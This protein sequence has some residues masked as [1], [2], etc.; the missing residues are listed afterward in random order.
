M[1]RLLQL[2]C[3]LFIAQWS[4]AQ[5]DSIPFFKG[6]LKANRD[7]AYLN[8][9]N[10]IVKKLSLPLVDSTEQDWI[11]AFYS[12]ELIRYKD[13]W[14]VSKIR[15][16]FDSISTRSIDFQVALLE[17][18][19]ANYPTQF[20]D[21]IYV[22]GNETMNAKVYAMV[23][24]YMVQSGDIRMAGIL[25]TSL[26]RIP[27]IE[28]SDSS[29]TS[30]A[31]L[32]A[33][34]CK[35]KDVTDKNFSKKVKEIFKKK[36]LL[37]NTIVYSI[38]RK[39]RN[40]P[41]I[42]IVKDKTGSYVKDEKGNIFSVPQLARSITNMPGYI[43]NGNTPQGIFRMD[44]FDVSRSGAI[45]PTTN[46]QLMMPLETSVQHFLKDSSITDTTWT[47]TLYACLL[48]K[49]LKKYHS[50]YQTYMASACGRTEIIAH[51]T[52]VNP[53]YYKGTSYYPLTPTEGCLATKEIWSEVN[54]KRIE[55]DQQKLVDAVKKAGGA[56]GYYIVIE[57]D[58]QQ[59]AVTI[60]ELLPLL[61]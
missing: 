52:T 9:Q 5:N 58:D 39:N 53:E 51:G 36:Y 46:I 50:L 37:S 32:E 55:S 23:G 38:Q 34:K 14:A 21:Q 8:I 48:P 29:K 40:Y 2:F 45:G 49:A 43:N 26:K 57:I 10:A 30:K 6:A 3:L 59:K 33:T 16:A 41:G 31:F 17:V 18:C 15:T 12:M 54:G 4:F 19:Y 22:L 28:M 7:K 11:D 56:D 20:I 47:K 24:E 60:G 13:E 44:G 61:K 27:L 1:I 25:L 42:V 35:V